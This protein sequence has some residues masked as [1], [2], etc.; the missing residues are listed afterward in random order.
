MLLGQKFIPISRKISLKTFL[1]EIAN[2]GKPTLSRQKYFRSPN[3]NK[4]C[5]NP[6]TRKNI[7]YTF[8]NCEKGAQS[9][10]PLW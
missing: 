9:Y 4:E 6:Y 1:K 8:T 3:N 7:I 10:T 2:E 5:Y